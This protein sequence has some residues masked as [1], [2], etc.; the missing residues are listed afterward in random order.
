M[1]TTTALRFYREWVHRS[2]VQNGQQPRFFEADRSPAQMDPLWHT[3]KADERTQYTRRS[4][5]ELPAV[6]QFQKP[7]WKITRLGIT[8][9]RRDNFLV[10]TLDLQ[11]LDYFPTRG[12]AVRSSSTTRRALAPSACSPP[13]DPRTRSVTASMPGSRTT[14]ENALARAFYAPLPSSRF[15]SFSRGSRLGNKAVNGTRNAVQ[16]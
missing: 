3:P 4:P 5:M 8:P 10:S 2:S 9:G 6:N 11:A 1:D 7:D 12:D 15:G 16:R 14:T 13:G